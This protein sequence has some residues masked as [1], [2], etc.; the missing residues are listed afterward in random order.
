MLLI[1]RGIEDPEHRKLMASQ[2]YA[3]NGS[4]LPERIGDKGCSLGIPQ[5]NFCLYGISAKTALKRYPVWKDYKFQLEW[6]ADKAREDY[7]RF[8]SNVFLSIIFHNCPVC[9]KAGKDNGYYKKVY[10]L[11]MRFTQAL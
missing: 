1:A 7:N 4:L 10:N 11:S 8:N 9:A 6:M 2:I 3:E 5:R